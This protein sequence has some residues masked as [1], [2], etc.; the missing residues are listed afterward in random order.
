[1]DAEFWH[2]RWAENR[3]GFHLQDTNPVLSKYWPAVNATRSD[4]VLVPMCGKSVDLTWLAQKHDTVVG[5]EL[6]D[7]AVRAFF[8][9]HFYTPT[10]TTLGNGQTMYEFDEITIYC[11][12]FF[13]TRIEP[14]DVVYDRA[15]LIA[16]PQ[17]MRQLYAD[18]LL[19]MVKADGR[20][21][22][23]TLDYPQA[24]MDGPPFSVTKGEI[25]QLFRGCK[26]TLLGRDEADE[27]HPRRQRGLSRFAE[28]TW[29]IER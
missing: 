13:A 27:S 15:A 24:E 5:I 6:S 21:L 11:G 1:M 26:I 28:E 9:E 22:L 25:E 16:M 2:S 20:I 12:D 19:S 29:L 3:I 23:V 8:A 18:Q 14:V 7:I 10:V 4:S 17:E